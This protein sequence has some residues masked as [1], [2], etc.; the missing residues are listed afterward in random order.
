[1]IGAINSKDRVGS[2][3]RAKTRVA[4]ALIIAAALC[5][6]FSTDALAYR[7]SS[8]GPLN[9]TAKSINGQ[10]QL[11]WDAPKI[12]PTSVT[13]YKILRGNLQTANR[14]V[15]LF[16]I[17]DTDGGET[18]YIDA[19]VFPDNEYTYCVQAIRGGLKSALSNCVDVVASE[20]SGQTANDSSSLIPVE[21]SPSPSCIIESVI[22]DRIL[23]EK[24]IGEGYETYEEAHDTYPS[25]SFTVNPDC[26]VPILTPVYSSVFIG[27]GFNRPKKD[28]ASPSSTRS[29]NQSSNPTPG[30]AEKPTPDTSSEPTST[31]APT[32]TPTP[33]NDS[34]TPHK[35]LTGEAAC[36][37]DTEVL[38]KH[39]SCPR[40]YWSSGYPW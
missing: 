30:S 7:A 31:V 37:A 5:F 13:G 21:A 27:P 10:I 17:A 18:E 28:P 12:D 23:I 6:W 11:N 39:I 38:Y 24:L 4:S 1:M 19:N 20:N 9:L 14:L 22:K 29:S 15:S 40:S 34:T 2:I 26:P 33:K 25:V 36:Y 16:S 32:S 8:S 3:A 35:T